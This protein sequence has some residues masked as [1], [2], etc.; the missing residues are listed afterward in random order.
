[1]FTENLILRAQHFSYCSNLGQKNS[2]TTL[3]LGAKPSH[4]PPLS[5]ALS[6]SLPLLH[7]QSAPGS[8]RIRQDDIICAENVVLKA[9]LAS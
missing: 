3:L 8:L 4:S 9:L 1:M 6:L 7:T 2:L 5:S